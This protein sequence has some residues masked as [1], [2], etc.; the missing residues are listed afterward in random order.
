MQKTTLTVYTDI[1]K[2]PYIK[3]DLEGY[4]SKCKKF[5]IANTSN[6]PKKK[7]YSIYDMETKA[8]LSN[9]L[10][11]IKQAI[12]KGDQMYKDMTIEQWNYARKRFFD[13]QTQQ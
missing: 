6:N 11:S 13:R 1:S 2:V 5:F 7:L 4:I 9:W 8:L 3:T 10:P 12:E